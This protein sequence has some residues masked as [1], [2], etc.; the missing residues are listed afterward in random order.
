MGPL[1]QT[2]ILLSIVVGLTVLAPTTLAEPVTQSAPRLAEVSVNPATTISINISYDQVDSRA[3]KLQAYLEARGSIL[4]PYAT[5]FVKAADKYNLDWKLVAAISGN[6]SG[7]GQAYVLGT[8]NA[9]GWGGGYIRFGNW[10][11]AIYQVSAGL[12]QGYINKGAVT[13]SQIAPIYAPP[14]TTWAG[15]VQMYEN[16]IDSIK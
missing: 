9:W 16:Q 4:A 12:K 8:Y 10:S 1:K 3:L 2:L 11:D 5:D 13:P 7:F 6:E 15:N 14:S